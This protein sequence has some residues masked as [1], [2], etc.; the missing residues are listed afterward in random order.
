MRE[1][2]TIL[3]GSANPALA[4]A[5]AAELGIPLGAC[6]LGRFP[7]GELAVE[8]EESVRGHEVF[9]V[10]PTAP[11]VNDHFMELLLIADACRR[12]AAGRIVAV[13]PYFGYARSDRRQGRRTPITASAAAEL[14]T[15]LGIDHV[16]ALDVHTPQVEGFFHV[17]VENLSAVPVLC[18]EL[19]QRVASDTVVVSPDLGAVR[20]ATE[21]GQR[22]GLLTAV[23]HKQRVST[24]AVKVTQLIGDVRDRPCLIVDDMITTGGTIVECARALVAAGARA[25][26]TAA[27]THGVLVQGAR[28]ELASAGVCEL[29]VTDTIAPGHPGGLPTQVVS[30]APLLARAIEHVRSGARLRE[31]V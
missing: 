5:V 27:A 29:L 2:C 25:P 10:Q 13:V 9:I 22:L 19:A 15:A 12:A 21:Y 7:D 3:S 4:A 24:S 1:P 17:P 16:L 23:C 6:S 26:L 20:L 11:P 18:A 31:L 8:L 28:D 14:M 30:V